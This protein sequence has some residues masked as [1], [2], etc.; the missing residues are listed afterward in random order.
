MFLA[1]FY[2]LLALFLISSVVYMVYYITLVFVY[3]SYKLG[4]CEEAPMAKLALHKLVYH[5]RMFVLVT[6]AVNILVY[7]TDGG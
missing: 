3:Y 7:Y 5:Y 1:L 4:D 6:M 2:I